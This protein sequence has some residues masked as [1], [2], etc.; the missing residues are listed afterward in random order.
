M[1]FQKMSEIV[2]NAN[3]LAFMIYLFEKARQEIADPLSG[4]VSLMMGGGR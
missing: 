4:L 3:E 1:R 2:E